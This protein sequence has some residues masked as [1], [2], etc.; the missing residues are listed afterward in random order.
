MAELGIT[1]GYNAKDLMAKAKEIMS[2][3][4]ELQGEA[5]QLNHQVCLLRKYAALYSFTI[6]QCSIEIPKIV[7]VK[8]FES[9]SPV[10]I[11]ESSS[12]ILSRNNVHTQVHTN[13]TYFWSF[14]AFSSFQY[15]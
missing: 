1:N 13:Y 5:V 2:H 14:S 4:H 15:S 11:K 8:H 10:L 12:I 3:H 9:Q 7:Y 6:I